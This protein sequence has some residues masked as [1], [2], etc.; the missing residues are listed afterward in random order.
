MTRR[1][2]K[3][4]NIPTASVPKWKKISPF[5]YI[6]PTT[7]PPKLE[8]VLDHRTISDKVG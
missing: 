3:K 4:S 5:L 7:H 8:L 2:M 6:Q 1:K